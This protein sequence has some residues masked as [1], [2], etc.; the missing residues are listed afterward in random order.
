MSCRGER[1]L[2]DG[3]DPALL[4]LPVRQMEKRDREAPLGLGDATGGGFEPP[5]AKIAL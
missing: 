2:P 3:G 5:L 1:S 4:R